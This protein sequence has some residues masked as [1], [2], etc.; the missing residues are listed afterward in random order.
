MRCRGVDEFGVAGSWS[1]TATITVSH[2]V[3]AI[4][5]SPTGDATLQYAATNRFSWVFSGPSSS[6][7]QTAYQIVVE[8]N[9]TG[10]T[11]KDTG[12]VTSTNKYADIAL[13]TGAID[14]PLRWKIQLWDGSNTTQG[15]GN[16]QLFRV[17]NPPTVTISAPAA[18]GTVTTGQPTVTWS[19]DA[20]TVQ[21]SRRV[22]F[23]RQ[24]DGAVL[25]DSGTTATSSQSYT[26]S[27]NIL[28]NGLTFTV[29][30]Y[31]TDTV[32]LSGNST[33][34]FTTSYVAPNAVTYSVDG[35]SMEWDGYVLVD[36]SSTTPDA[37]FASWR[38]YRR[39]ANTGEDW[40]LIFTTDNANI[41][42]Y[43]DWL[44]GANDYWEYSVT[45][46]ALRS[47]ELV[48]SGVNASPLPVLASSTHYWII[49]PQNTDN[50]LRLDQVTA[51]TY[52]EAYDQ[53]ELV[54][55]GRGRKVNLGTRHGYDGS[56]TV[57]MRDDAQM[58]ARQ[59]R[60]K[61]QALRENQTEYYLRNP[62]GDT[63][64]ISLGDLQFGRIAGVGTNEW[65]DVTVPYKEVS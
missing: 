34:T 61:L 40:E 50:S 37:S 18:G 3:G 17:S 64:K 38:V 29:T 2:I 36:W 6:S 51:D 39:Y 31:V 20:N 30:V 10:A 54:I 22:V 8:N 24:S 15:Y 21:Q 4:N 56:L 53:A 43:E 59:K 41:R 33:N 13:G 46:M 12:K 25:H 23:K 14:Q 49:D 1:S 35:N 16:Y 52:T 32:G 58:T 28:S 42:Q 5:Q 45:Q 7:V 57:K 62:F 47:G 27:T 60:R 19:N 9:D 26:P 44:A 11:V 48:E 55:I 65:V 63:L